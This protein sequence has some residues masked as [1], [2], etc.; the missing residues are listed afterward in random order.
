MPIFKTNSGKNTWAMFSCWKIGEFSG[1]KNSLQNE[2]HKNC[3]NP[4]FFQN[5]KI[6]FQ[7]CIVSYILTE[8]SKGKHSRPHGM[9]SNYWSK[10]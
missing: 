4:S 2:N 5:L 7:F 8:T 9:S 10:F 3:L 6:I 1:K